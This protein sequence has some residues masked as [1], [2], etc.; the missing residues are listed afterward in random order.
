MVKELELLQQYKDKLIADRT[1]NEIIMEKLKADIQTLPE[2]VVEQLG[3][4]DI[5]LSFK[6]LVPE[7]Y[8]EDIDPGAYEEQ[9]NR[10]SSI[11]DK[12][13]EVEGYD[14]EILIAPWKE[15]AKLR[16]DEKGEMLDAKEVIENA[17]THIGNYITVPIVIGDEE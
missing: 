10:A 13:N 17:P 12:I 4:K 3:V 8:K 16:E 6:S 11:V 5:D 2:D 15:D 9:F 14:D 1:K 7:M